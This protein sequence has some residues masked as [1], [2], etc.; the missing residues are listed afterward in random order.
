MK[1][2]KKGVNGRRREEEEEEM[3]DDDDEKKKG[4][5]RCSIKERNLYIYILYFIFYV[6]KF[7][8]GT[9]S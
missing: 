1:G 4:R 8:L 6:M 7:V 2:G 9:V 5:R 3:A